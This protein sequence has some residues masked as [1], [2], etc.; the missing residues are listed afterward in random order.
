LQSDAQKAARRWSAAFDNY[1]CGI[2]WK[3][4]MASFMS[5]QK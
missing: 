1:R 3:D 4:I 5:D 2:Y